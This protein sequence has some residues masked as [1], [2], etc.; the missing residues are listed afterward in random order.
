MY[1]ILATQDGQITQLTKA[2]I[3]IVK[4]AETIGIIVPKKIDYIAEIYVKPVDLPLIRENQKVMLTFDG[5]P[6][7]VFSGWPNS[8]YG[9][10]LEKLLP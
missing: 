2:G 5:F 9:T 3:E 4:D 7:I 6:A 1:Y 10:F 8:S